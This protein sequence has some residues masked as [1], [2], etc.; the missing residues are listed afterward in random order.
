[1][2][3]APQSIGRSTRVLAVLGAILAGASDLPARETC[4]VEVKLLLS[5]QAAD[6][7]IGS[8]GLAKKSASRVYFFDTETLDLFRQRVIVR[9]RQGADND[10]TIKVRQPER[11]EQ[12]HPERLHGRFPCEIDQTRDGGHVSYSVGNS[13]KSGKVPET[14]KD[15][16]KLLSSAQARLLREAG[17]SIDWERVKRVA[18]IDSTKWTTSAQSP[19]GKLALELWNW[20]EGAILELSARAGAESAAAAYSGLEQLAQAKGL[21]LSAI[22]DTKTGTVLQSHPAEP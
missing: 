4:P 21:A 1:M 5:A 14:G 18:A 17:A 8:L 16:R 6:N 20:P 2:I 10:L 12:G 22:Q 7:A 11:Q 9:V 15:V 3:R 19:N 13:V